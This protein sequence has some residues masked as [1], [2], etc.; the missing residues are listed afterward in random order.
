MS[1]TTKL[2][3]SVLSVCIL[4]I[5]YILLRPYNTNRNN[6][7]ELPS[8]SQQTKTDDNTS[9][10]EQLRVETPKK[11]PF[12]TRKRA[13]Q[14]AIPKKR[15]LPRPVSDKI[16][17]PVQLSTDINDVISPQL[18][19]L[20]DANTVIF[21]LQLIPDIQ[22]F[23]DPMHVDITLAVIMGKY[24]Q[25][26]IDLEYVV[27]FLESQ[28]IY[29]PTILEKLEPRRAFRYFNR[30]LVSRDTVKAYAERIL[31]KD[32]D[33]P[34]AQAHMVRYEKDNTK[35]A[36]LY[37]KILIKHP[38]HPPTLSGL[39]YRL[40]DHS[41]EEALQYLK[42]AN[43]LDPTLGL[44]GLGREYERLGDVKTAWFCYKKSITIRNRENREK[45]KFP[46]S[47]IHVDYFYADESNLYAIEGGKYW[48][49][50]IKLVPDPNENTIRKVLTFQS[51]NAQQEREIREFYQFRDWVQNILSRKLVNRR[52]D[53]LI[54]EVERHLEGG[55]PMFDPE[56]I[57]RAYEITTRYPGKEG[58]QRLKKT[59]PEVALEIE[60]LLKEQ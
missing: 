58:V 22:A 19:P 44:M 55:K 43:L 3:I 51:V 46:P 40:L 5:G 9:Q 14:H 57:V 27:D 7:V 56:R 32:P 18:Q 10:N 30:I 35:A 38:N 31:A 21:P 1:K 59:D 49:S 34:D 17:S 8:I 15:V 13:R 12:L 29:K 60:R 52:S 36:A 50:A 2:L 25:G 23:L 54:I 6:D 47:L 4:V 37:R 33:N 41:P 42:R 11:R 20:S 48:K 16:S 28:H 24:K 26:K 39:G 45:E 53:F